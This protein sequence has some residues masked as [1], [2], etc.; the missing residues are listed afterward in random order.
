MAKEN[1]ISK[2][3]EKQSLKLGETVSA[4]GEN[5]SNFLTDLADVF[6]FIVNIVSF[7]FTE[8]PDDK[9]K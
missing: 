2:V 1:Q 5:A 8:A 7:A 3:I 4:Q 9:L 6:L